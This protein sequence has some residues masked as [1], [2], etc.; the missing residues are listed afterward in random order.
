[1]YNNAKAI[2][3]NIEAEPKSKKKTQISFPEANPT[4]IIAP[5]IKK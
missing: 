3:P 4:P 1:M 5:N 2:S